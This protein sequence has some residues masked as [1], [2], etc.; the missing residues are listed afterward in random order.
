MPL[1]TSLPPAAQRWLDHV[2]PE[3]VAIPSRIQIKQE[4]TMDIRDRWTAIYSRGGL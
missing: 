1:P 2:L 4:G 3:N